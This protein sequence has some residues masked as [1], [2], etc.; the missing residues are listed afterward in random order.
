MIRAG[1]PLVFRGRLK[2]VTDE[3]RSRPFFAGKE[4]RCTDFFTP[5]GIA[6]VHRCGIDDNVGAALLQSSGSKRNQPCLIRS[7]P[8][9]CESPEVIGKEHDL[10]V[11]RIQFPR[12]ARPP[13]QR[14][15]ATWPWRQQSSAAGCAGT[16]PSLANPLLLRQSGHNLLSKSDQSASGCLRRLSMTRRA[17]RSMRSRPGSLSRSRRWRSVSSWSR[18]VR[19]AQVECATEGTA[20]GEAIGERVHHATA[21]R[22]EARKGF[23]GIAGDGEHDGRGAADGEADA[24]QQLLDVDAA[25]APRGCG[26]VRAP[27]PCPMRPG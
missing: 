26:P 2:A 24:R 19:P 11:H 15:P 9:P 25:P 22:A 27:S 21:E 17:T 5:L 13:R 1:R 6:H 23:H 14:V 8:M 20:E 4:T 18:R 3:A 7:R 10:A 12:F 16:W